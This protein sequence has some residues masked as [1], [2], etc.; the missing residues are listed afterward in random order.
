MLDSGCLLTGTC[1]SFS[2]NP[3]I[4]AIFCLSS[5][6]GTL[7]WQNSLLQVSFCEWETTTTPAKKYYFYSY[8]SAYKLLWLSGSFHPSGEIPSR[9]AKY[10]VLRTNTKPHQLIKHIKISNQYS[11]LYFQIFVRYMP[12]RS[13][14]RYLKV[15]PLQVP[16]EVRTMLVWYLLSGI[17]ILVYSC[18]DCST[19]KFYISL[20]E[21]KSSFS[22]VSLKS[23]T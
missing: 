9:K 22:L 5:Y 8:H 14:P 21:N 15:E 10:P 1:I 17:R 2:T 19:S 7:R 11:H 18:T 4:N 16:Q 23:K 12:K 3:L 13:K 20:K 6:A